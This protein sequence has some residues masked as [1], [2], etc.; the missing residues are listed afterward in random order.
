M[1]MET[2]LKV[3]NSFG[4]AD[5]ASIT[6]LRE[7]SDN[8]VYRVLDSDTYILRVSKKLPI[9]D[10]QFEYEAMNHLRSKGLPVPNWVSSVSGTP[11]VVTEDGAVAVLFIF[12]EGEHVSVTTTS[13]PTPEESYAAGEAL[14]KI[15]QAGIDFKSEA[16]RAR[17]VFSELER[18]V[19]HKE[20]ISEGVEGGAQ[21]IEEVMRVL[22][23]AHSTNYSQGLLHNDFRPS[24]VFFAKDHSISGLVDF[25][26]ACHGPLIK[27]VALAALEWSYPDGAEGPDQKLFESFIEGYNATA[28]EQVSNGKHLYLWI[29][30]SALSDAATFLCDRLGSEQQ[31]KR[32]A[33]SYMYQKYRHFLV[34]YETAAVS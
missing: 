28:P 20:Q 29:M 33:G 34:K 10:A 26:W 32:I 30:V 22:E 21:F 17:T 15:A 27:D 31:P 2:E 5:T 8:S 23:L 6:P 9:S 16:P 4:L 7:S 1:I 18:G 14:G 25:D 3:L 12:I 13:L 24:N 11:Y 19:L